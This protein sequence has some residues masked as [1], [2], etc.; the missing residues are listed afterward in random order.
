ML[1]LVTLGIT[2]QDELMLKLSPTTIVRELIAITA[3]FADWLK[4]RKARP[5]RGRPALLTRDRCSK[6][7]WTR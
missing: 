7:R 1:F 5:H 4:I 3:R 2:L 6:Y